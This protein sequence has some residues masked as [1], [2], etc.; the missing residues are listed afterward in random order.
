M[1]LVPVAK[2]GALSRL[3]LIAFAAARVA[4]IGLASGVDFVVGV[5]SEV[6]GGPFGIIG[7]RVAGH[8]PRT[9]GG[10]VTRPRE[11]AARRPAGR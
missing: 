2:G 5:F 9:I 3:N 1:V 6:P 7:D 4:P 11:K 10:V 8:L